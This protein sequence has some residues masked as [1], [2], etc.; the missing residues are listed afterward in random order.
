[1]ARSLLRGFFTAAVGL[2]VVAGLSYGGYAVAGQDEGRVIRAAKHPIPG[3]YVVFLREGRQTE[4]PRSIADTSRQ[5]AGR[6]GGT[7]RSVWDTAVHGFSVTSLTDREAARLAADP[8]VRQVRQSGTARAIDEQANPPS[9]GQDRVDQRRLPLDRKY[10]YNAT[11][12]G[13]NVYVVDTGIRFDHQ[14]F[15]GRAKLGADFIN[16]GRNG[17]DCTGHGTHV[18]GTIGG[19]TVG[20]AKRATLIAVRMLGTNC[21]SSGPDS[22]GVDALNWVA[23]NAVKPAVINMSWGFDDAHLGDEALRAVDAAGITMVAAAGNNSSDG[24]SFGPGGVYPP[25][26]DV[27]STDSNDSR[28]SFSNYGRCLDLFAPGGSIYSSMHSG[29]SAY[30]QMSGTSMASP[31]VAGGVALY[32]QGNPGATPAQAHEFVVSGATADVVGN[33]G[34]GSP[35]KLFYSLTGTPPPPGNDFSISVSPTSLTV[36]QG[37]YGSASITTTVVS[38]SAETVALSSDGLPTG[39]TATFQPSSV[40]AGEQA[41]L[42]IDVSS[43]TSPGSYPVRI[44]GTADSA[45]HNTTLTLVVTDPGGGNDFDMSLNPTSATVRSGE[46]TTS[47]V[48][49]TVVSGSAETIQLSASGQPAGV[50]VSFDPSSVTA[51]NSATMAVST[52]SSVPTGSYPITVTGRAASATHSVEFTLNVKKVDTPPPTAGIV[53][54]GF[55]TGNLNGWTV[56]G[57]AGVTSPGR[58]GSYAAKLGGSGGTSSLSQ[59]FTVPSGKTWLNVAFIQSGCPFNPGDMTTIELIDTATGFSRTLT[60]Q[61]CFNSSMW[62][63]I[64]GGVTA[65]RSYKLV[66]RHSNTTGTS[67]VK[68]DDVT[69]N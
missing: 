48:A 43:G 30:G 39:A 3:H 56:T 22:A 47:T 37:S 5:L 11:G 27:G 10:T 59:T 23:R 57:T 40:T 19:R 12:S 24:C 69:L 51:G 6:H 33:P 50:T 17:V 49:T 68:V 18:A 58:T 20:L 21:S 53:N 29:T 42:S 67:T 66:I 54:G 63:Q 7:L 31:H 14:E 32:L 55:E 45:T 1:L 2:A 44:T 16:D 52:T 15:E 4:T 8:R 9:W 41:K 25:I 28:S 36:K 38:G 65:G 61:Y 26:I 60:Q 64:T 34:S 46:S 13:V 35:N 62:W